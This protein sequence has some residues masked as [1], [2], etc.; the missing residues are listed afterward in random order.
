MVAGTNTYAFQWAEIAYFLRPTGEMTTGTNPLPLHGLYRN[1]RLLSPGHDYLDVSATPFNPAAHPEISIGPFTSPTRCNSPAT[2]T[3]PTNRYGGMMSDY[4][5]EGTTYGNRNLLVH[6]VISFDVRLM[7]KRPNGT[8]SDFSDLFNGD[9]ASYWSG[10]FPGTQANTNFSNSN[11][12]R[13]FDT[14]SRHR[15]AF[16]NYRLWRPVTGTPADR[17]IPMYGSDADPIQ[18]RAVQIQL[19]VWDPKTQQ[20]RQ[21]TIVQD[22]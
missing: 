14:W 20:S 16:D 13:V 9:V 10:S 2:V 22:L 3:V 12:P 15:D 4:S 21:V 17:R 18:V 8:F 7:I 1:V 19:R 11:G 5:N 6:D